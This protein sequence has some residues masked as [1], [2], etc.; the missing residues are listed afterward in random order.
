MIEIILSTSSG[1]SSLNGLEG[2]LTIA[3]GGSLTVGTSG[4]DI[5]VNLN[6]ANANTWTATQTFSEIIDL[7]N[8]MNL[9]VGG[10]SQTP[11]GNSFIGFYENVQTIGDGM[12]QAFWRDNGNYLAPFLGE[13]NNAFYF[14]F[15]N[16]S[17]TAVGSLA[18]STISTNMVIG[19]G[20]VL[21]TGDTTIAYPN[22]GLTVSFTPRNTLDD[23]SGNMSIAGTLNF[24]TTGINQIT[25]GAVGGIRWNSGSDL[26]MYAPSGEKVGLVNNI[27]SNFGLYIIDAA[28]PPAYTLHN[29][30]DDG[31]G[32]MTI[33]GSKGIELNNGAF[34]NYFWVDSEGVVMFFGNEYSTPILD[35]GTNVTQ[36]NAN[37]NG[38]PAPN[39]SYGG[40]LFRFDLRTSGNPSGLTG[41]SSTPQW[42]ILLQDS[43][44]SGGGT[45]YFGV[46]S[47]GRVS[48]VHNILDDGS[49]NMTVAG[50][51]ELASRFI[52][53]TTDGANA[54]NAQNF[55]A[56]TVYAGYSITFPYY[57]SGIVLANYSSTAETPTIT[58]NTGGATY[59]QSWSNS[60]TT[61]TTPYF[62]GLFSGFDITI[63]AATNSG[64]EIYV[65]WWQTH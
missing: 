25:F 62:I 50:Y 64:S 7:S 10:G 17:S 12:Y 21:Q 15:V 57:V 38:L 28:S 56:N 65:V 3:S 42:Y 33:V 32:N 4:S 34:G 14:G 45:P 58:A 30:L 48:T 19:T 36:Q 46:D 13:Q 18:G 27:Q 1:V 47:G 53:G 60:Y 26:F 20:G 55:G 49:G 41:L 23:G 9:T 44:A 37:S 59:M 54:T 31:S 24:P 52:Q 11:N 39:T 35:V 8:S 63:T 61:F 29:T 16:A 5:N 2:S 22:T 40:G 43:G 6:L 51:I